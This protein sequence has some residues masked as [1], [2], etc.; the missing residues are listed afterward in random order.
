MKN[1]I[2]N[3]INTSCGFA[4]SFSLCLLFLLTGCF[5]SDPGKRGSGLSQEAADSLYT[6]PAAMSIHRADPGRALVMIDSGVIVGNITKERGQ[7]LKA[8]TQYSGLN[9]LSL[10]RQTCL[11][12]LGHQP[13]TLDSVTLMDTYSLLVSIE[14]H[15]DNHADVIRYATEASRLAHLNDDL[16]EVG[17]ME[18]TIAEMMLLMGNDEEGI[19]RLRTVIEEMRQIDS[20]DGVK[21]YHYTTLRLFHI[22][23]EYGRYAEIP[24]YCQ[25]LLQRIDEL[26]QHPER[27]SMKEGFDPSEFIDLARGQTLAFLTTAYA[28]QYTAAKNPPMEMTQAARAQLL[29]KARETEAEM[30]KTKWS[31][32]IDCDRMMVAAYH[33]LGDFDRFDEAMSRLDSIMPDTISMNYL[34]WLHHNCIAAKMRGR[35]AESL[36]YLERA[37]VI[38]DS[39]DMRHQ[40]DQLNELATLYHLQ[41]EQLSRQQAE[42]EAER[43]HIIN[44]ALA[45]G[46]LAAIAFLVWFFRQKRIVEKKNHVLARQIGEIISLRDSAPDSLS[47]RGE[48]MDTVVGDAVMG[49]AIPADVPTSLSNHCSEAEGDTVVGDADSELFQ[50]LRTAIL[51][52]QLFLDPQLDR[53]ALCDRFGLSKER[54]GAA[55]AKGSPYKSLIEFLN[56]CRL[57]YAAKL[58]TERPELTIT[59]VAHESGFLNADT[60][61]RNFKQKY[62]LTPSQYQREAA[63]TQKS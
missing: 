10:S 13:S 53:Q 61:G 23:L 28:R 49:D 21:T 46:L 7:Y 34:I 25:S 57:P 63:K 20:F 11:D 27:F 51:R 4:Y 52:D 19:E 2:K 33:H 43:S 16:A 36:D 8:V 14:K 30:F 35:L 38:R 47:R 32:T 15:L 22:L 26:A 37:S 50:Q 5:L 17:K 45:I 62:A 3:T 29:K 40:R 24:P 56:D 48:S 12:L 59:D 58:L 31:H 18:A 44:I 60:F 41:E 54:I 9:D 6:E 39:L 42:A 1:M 55:F